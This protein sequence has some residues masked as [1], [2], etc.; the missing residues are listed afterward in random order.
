MT[1]TA[2]ALFHGKSAQTLG[3][4]ERAIYSTVAYRDVFDFPVTAGEIHRYLHGRH[5]GADEVDRALAGG[6]LCDRL[7]DTDG[8]FFALK[9][10]RNLFDIRRSRDAASSRQWL[11]ALRFARF[12]AS[13]PNVRMVAMTGSLAVGNFPDDG[14]I[15][16]LLL[17]DESTMWRTRALCRLFALADKKL[18]R[19]MFCPNMFL[20]R[21]E[22]TLSRRS[23]YDAQELSQMIPLY[24]Q[25]AYTQV[26]RANAWTEEYLPNATG[27]PL[28]AEC[29]EPSYPSLKGGA[30]WMLASP[31]G[32]ALEAF[33]AR[34]KIHRFNETNRLEGA[35]T[36]STP[37]AHSLWDDMRLKIESAWQR[38]METLVE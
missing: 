5:C 35:W 10:R 16:F 38:R 24:G 19:G 11:T 22:M 9:G 33:E 30:E 32:R 21:A 26:R 1:I 14:D 37:E 20:S 34:R 31:L 27:A 29:C 13:L 7:L 6:T 3:A 4:L 28:I 36:L 2:T 12:L 15:D 23:L 25:S 17:C 8:E 18:R